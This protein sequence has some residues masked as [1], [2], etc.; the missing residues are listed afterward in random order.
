MRLPSTKG[1]TVLAVLFMMST[2]PYGRAQNETFTPAE[3]TIA[4]IHAAMKRGDLT[5]ARLVRMYL[6]R[7][8]AYDQTG[9]SLNAVIM[10]NPDAVA[11]AEELD[12]RFDQSGLTGPL[13]GIPILL[14]DNVNTADMPTTGGSLSLEG[15]IPPDDAFIT[16]RLREAGAIVLAKVNL[17]EF[18]T[19]GVTR[20]SLLGQTLNPYDLTRT[21]GG[22]S[23]GTGA[24]GVANF[25]VMGIGTD[26]VNSIRSPASAIAWSAFARLSAL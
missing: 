5:A 15:S 4:D 13:H 7:I 18:A 14:K 1:A 9:P 6:A 16:K 20:S 3:A 8:E 24:G 12:V 2:S 19:S 17:H 22:S 23:G 25:G 21:P 26:T 10:V 11:R